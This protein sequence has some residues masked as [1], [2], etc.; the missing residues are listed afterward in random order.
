MTIKLD[1]FMWKQALGMLQKVS[2][3]E[4]KDAV[5]SLETHL[6]EAQFRA[7]IDGVQAGIQRRW[8]TSLLKP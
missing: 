8:P 1:G 2:P 7:L 6:S 3:K 5:V 4:L